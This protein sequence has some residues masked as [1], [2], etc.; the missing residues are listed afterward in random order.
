MIQPRTMNPLGLKAP[1]DRNRLQGAICR[2]FEPQ[3]RAAWFPVWKQYRRNAS[4]G[5]GNGRL[6]FLRQV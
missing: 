3:A 1:L 2:G 5:E 4:L 6:V